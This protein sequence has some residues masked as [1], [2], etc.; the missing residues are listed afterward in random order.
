MPAQRL[1]AALH[2]CADH[3]A[4]PAPSCPFRW[5]LSEPETWP[6]HGRPALPDFRRQ[7]RLARSSSAS[8]PSAS[9]ASRSPAGRRTINTHCSVRCAPAP[10]SSA[11]SSLLASRWLASILLSQSLRLRDIVDRQSAH[12]LLSWNILRRLP[13]RGLLYLSDLGLRRNQSRALRLPEAETELD[14]RLSHRIQLDEVRHVLH[15]RIRQHDH[16]RLRRHVAFL[17]RMVRAPLDIFCPTSAVPSSKRCCRSS[18][19]SPRSSSSSFYSSGC[20][21]RC[22]ASVTTN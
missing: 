2:P 8:L 11:T 17:R 18:G 7:H 13:D 15:G 9:T 14:S 19:S 1:S 4:Q 20:A 12:G 16:R 10:R 6:L 3:R 22:R 21:E 5:F